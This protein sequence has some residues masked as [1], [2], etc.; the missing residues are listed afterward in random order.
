MTGG[1]SPS[2]RRPAPAHC[3][4]C[5]RRGVGQWQ[6]ADGGQ[7]R[8]CRY[9]RSTWDPETWAEAKRIHPDP[10]PKIEIT[11]ETRWKDK[12]GRTWQVFENLHFGRYWALCVDKPGYAGEW[13]AKEIKSAIAAE[14]VGGAHAESMEVG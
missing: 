12:K 3:P 4:S 9:C 6:G 13:T 7:T 8:R 5:S 2:K 11:R 10:P 1:A 14:T